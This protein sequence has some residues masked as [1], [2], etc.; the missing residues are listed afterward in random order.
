MS[1]YNPKNNIHILK[2]FKFIK[3]EVSGNYNSIRSSLSNLNNNYNAVLL[4]NCMVIDIPPYNRMKI[5]L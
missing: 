5:N 1:I 2:R 4:E 3:N